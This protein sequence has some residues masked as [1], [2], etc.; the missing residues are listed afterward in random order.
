MNTTVPT[1]LYAQ[2]RA[3]LAAQ[4]GGNG[5]AV[6]PTAPEAPRNRDTDFPYRHDSYFYYLTGFTEPEAC[7][8][9]SLHAATAG[10]PSCSAARRTSSARSGTATATAPKPRA[11]ASASTR[12][13]PIDE[14][15]AQHARAA[16]Q[17]RR[18]CS[19]RLAVHAGARQ[20]VAGWL[21]AVRAQ[22]RATASPRPRAARDLLR[23]ARRDAPGQGRARAGDH[24]ARR[25][26]S[27]ARAHARAMQA[28]ARCRGQRARIP[29]RSRAA[30]R[31]PPQRR[32][33]PGLQ[34]RSSP[35]AP[36][37]ACCTTAPTTRQMRDGDLLLIDAG[38][39]LD[40]Y[41]SDI[42][43]TFPVD[44]RFTGP[45]RALYELVLASQEARRRRRSKPGARFTD[46]HDAAV[47]VLAQ[48]ML[49]LG[50]LDR[51]KVGSA[52]RRDRRSAR[53]SRSTCTA[54]ATGWAWTCTTAAAT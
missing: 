4:L 42:T 38:C 49:D 54:P 6:I 45:Q 52:R 16:G 17:P 1:S 30:A 23:A 44:G 14:L 28:C 13:I 29:A 53:T 27:P 21:N 7:W 24:A 25:P 8:C 2:R 3:R 19:T 11:S 22:R 43:R 50:L 46:P 26:R 18:R 41:A 39:E 35:P 36:T 5:I 47:R 48:G 37:P 51:N 15:D 34:L 9:W 33:V 20:R 31:V 12:R 40:G 32:A 10:T